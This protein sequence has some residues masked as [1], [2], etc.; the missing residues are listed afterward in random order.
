MDLPQRFS[1]FLT[2]CAGDFAYL[3]TVIG[4]V[5]ADCGAVPFEPHV[6]VYSGRYVGPDVTRQA[7]FGA[8][9][10]MAPFSLKGTGIGFSLEYFKT[11]FIEFEESPLLREIHDR[12]K[13]AL[14]ED[15]GYRLIPHLSLLYSEMPLAEKEAVARRTAL[16]RSEI[17]FDRVKIVVPRNPDQG[18]R[19]IG[20]WATMFSA[21]LGGA[22][23]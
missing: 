17:L 15:S 13:Q 21:T 18:W 11:L 1:L 5:S 23:R 2:P 10:G 4:K 22:T 12:M 6:T 16:D 14:G 8:V 3:E 9:R 7:M 19:D 20:R